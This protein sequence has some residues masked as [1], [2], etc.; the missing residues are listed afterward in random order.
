MKYNT[1]QESSTVDGKWKSSILALTFLFALIDGWR[2]DVFRSHWKL[3]LLD[4]S[5]RPGYEFVK[6]FIHFASDKYDPVLP[7]YTLVCIGLWLVAVI[8]ILNFRM[9]EK[10]SLLK[11]SLL[12]GFIC[13]FFSFMAIIAESIGRRA[14]GGSVRLLEQRHIS[15]RTDVEGNILT[16]IVILSIV[17]LLSLIKTLRFSR[18]SRR[19]GNMKANP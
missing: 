9:F 13:C 17:L 11:F 1:H 10:L 16:C 5:P 12:G 18:S 15:H 7:F 6:S 19:K 2:I 4:E 14:F 8:L 3:F